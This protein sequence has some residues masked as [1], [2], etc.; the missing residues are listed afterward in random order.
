ML[1]FPPDHIEGVE[2]HFKRDLK[3]ENAVETIKHD[4]NGYIIF[5]RP[6][7]Q[8]NTCIAYYFPIINNGLMLSKDML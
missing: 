7:S 4:F 3:G 1:F 6:I 8:L 2:K 5:P